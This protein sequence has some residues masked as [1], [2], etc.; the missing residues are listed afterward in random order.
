MML[1]IVKYLGNS[2]LVE[3]MLE[4]VDSIEKYKILFLGSGNENLYGVLLS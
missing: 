3:E 4:F 1:D 2:V